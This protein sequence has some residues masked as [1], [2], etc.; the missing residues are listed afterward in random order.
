MFKVNRGYIWR[1][2]LKIKKKKKSKSPFNGKT[3]A[4]NFEVAILTKTNQGYDE[5]LFSPHSSNHALKLGSLH[6]VSHN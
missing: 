4:C 2:C 6:Q 3:K 1:P 5:I